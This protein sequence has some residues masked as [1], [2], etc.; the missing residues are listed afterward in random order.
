MDI[1]HVR[2]RNSKSNNTK[3]DV[4]NWKE[5]Y[6]KM[7]GYPWD[8]SDNPNALEDSLEAFID[9]LLTESIREKEEEIAVLQ[10]EL[11]PYKATEHMQSINRAI[12]GGA[13]DLLSPQEDKQ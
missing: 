2:K 9:Q 5:E 13:Y 12:S 8:E 4:R 11:G 10:K 3:I 1:K 7:F 6:R